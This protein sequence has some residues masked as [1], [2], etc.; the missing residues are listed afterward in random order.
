MKSW[1]LASA[2]HE[3]SASPPFAS[4]VLCGQDCSAEEE[5]E[6]AEKVETWTAFQ[7]FAATP[8]WPPPKASHQRSAWAIA[9]A[10]QEEQTSYETLWKASAIIFIPPRGAVEVLKF[11]AEKNS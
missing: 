5:S 9:A 6:T 3:I 7:Y 11:R 1:L 2:E 4:S 10:L 8:P